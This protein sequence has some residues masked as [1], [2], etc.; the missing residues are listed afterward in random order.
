[1]SS[2][3]GEVVEEKVFK[4]PLDRAW[5]APIKRR[6]PRAVRL[7]RAFLQRHM[8]PEMIVISREVNEA[9][10]RRGIEGAPRHIMIRAIKD[11]DNVVTVTLAKE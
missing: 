4:I 6:T 8:K 7:L 11:R 1:V 2:R 10:W 5:I 3:R 9:I